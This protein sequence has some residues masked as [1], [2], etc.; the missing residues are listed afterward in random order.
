MSRHHQQS[1]GGAVPLSENEQ[2]QLE[3]IERAL[4]ADDP[5]F[6]ATVRSSDLRS[7]T[8]RRLVRASLVFSLGLTLL[9]FTF[10]SIAFGIAGF[11]LMFAG[12]MLGAGALR[13]LRGPADGLRVAPRP[14]AAGPTR[15]PR[16]QKQGWRDRVEDRWKRRWEERE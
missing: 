10:S 9:L 6:A 16:P 15:V 14:A 8:R 12:A 11:V 13:R 5:K 4:M 7:H 3:A 2:R 1:G